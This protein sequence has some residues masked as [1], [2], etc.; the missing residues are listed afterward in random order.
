MNGKEDTSNHIYIYEDY[1]FICSFFVVEI[2]FDD[3]F[4]LRF[5]AMVLN[6]HATQTTA[7]PGFA[8]RIIL[9]RP[10]HSSSFS[11]WPASI[12]LI[13]LVF[14]AQFLHQVFVHGLA[15]AGCKHTRIAQDGP[16]W[17][18]VFFSTSRKVVLVSI[19]HQKQCMPWL[20][21]GGVKVGAESWTR[22]RGPA[23]MQPSGNRGTQQQSS[24]NWKVEGQVATD[25]AYMNSWIL[26]CNGENRDN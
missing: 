16:W 20:W 18:G 1:V 15:T 17:I 25:F 19:S 22:Q 11:W 5:F 26:S 9:Q 6:N 2:C 24:E 21:C 7:L 13:W 23:F 12:K 14:G 8:S 4:G 10:A 3:I